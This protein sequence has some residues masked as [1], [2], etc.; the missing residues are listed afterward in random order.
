MFVAIRNT[1]LPNPSPTDILVDP[2]LCTISTSLDG[3]TW[4]HYTYTGTL[5]STSNNNYRNGLL[6]DI[7]Y[8]DDLKQIIIQYFF[9]L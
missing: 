8:S 4:I 3:S 9:I 7:L 1:I 2:Y 6:F 5:T